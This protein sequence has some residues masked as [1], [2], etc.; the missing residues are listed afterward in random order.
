MTTSAHPGIISTARW[1]PRWRRLDQSLQVGQHGR[2]WFYRTGEQHSGSG[3]TV[4]HPESGATN[5]GVPLQLYNRL[6]SREYPNEVREA[7]VIAIEHPWLGLLARVD[8]SG[9]DYVFR[10]LNGEEYFVNAE[11]DPGV[12]YDSPD[13]DVTD[14]SLTVTFQNLSRPL[15]DLA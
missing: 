9:L 6:V 15:G 1:E 5:A 8:T 12:V 10:T 11:E 7:T 2:W 13:L 14:W 4:H 3:Q